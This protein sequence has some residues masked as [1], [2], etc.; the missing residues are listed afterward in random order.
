[1]NHNFPA[2]NNN[3][4]SASGYSDFK[5][6]MWL[7]RQEKQKLASQRK[8]GGED[9]YST[10]PVHI[11]ARTRVTSEASAKASLDAA[12]AHSTTHR[13]VFRGLRERSELSRYDD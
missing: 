8:K 4:P 10:R 6:M 7:W 13:G 1:M 11:H 2:I 12:I 3:V 9:A 5:K